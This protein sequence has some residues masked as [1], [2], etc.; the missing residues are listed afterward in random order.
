[1]VKFKSDCKQLNIETKILNISHP[2]LTPFFPPPPFL[3]HLQLHLVPLHYLLQ[4]IINHFLSSPIFPSTLSTS[5]TSSITPYPPPTTRYPPPLSPFVPTYPP[6]SS[7]LTNLTKLPISPFPSFPS[8]H[9]ILSHHLSL[10]KPYP[11]PLAPLST[12]LITPYPPL[13]YHTNPYSPPP[14]SPYPPPPPTLTHL[15][16][17]NLIHLPNK[18]L[19][20]SPTNPYS[21]P[22]QNLIHLPNKPLPTSHITP[23]PTHR[24]HQPLPTSGITHYPT[25]ASPLTH[26][27]VHP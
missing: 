2:Y 17:Q 7:P 16:P 23:S 25:P 18:P 19:P 21:P 26:L 27:P 4:F 10:N 14:T 1:M 8:I 13:T 11:L 9:M 24:S 3:H 6:L 15:P 22:P 20:T 5:P 12:S